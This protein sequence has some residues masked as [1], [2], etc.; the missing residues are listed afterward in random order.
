MDNSMV[1]SLAGMANGYQTDN[2]G[3]QISTAVLKQQLDMQK[4]QND[5]LLNM[6]QKT[7]TPSP[8]GA[9]KVVDLFA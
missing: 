7:P 2:I 9:G 4:T 6:I 3:M 5:A 8:D 1:T